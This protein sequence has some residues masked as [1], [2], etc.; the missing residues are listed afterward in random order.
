MVISVIIPV[1]NGELAI[2]R[3][4]GSVINQTYKEIEIICVDDASTDDTPD[5]LKEYADKD[6][7]IHILTES[8]NVGTSKA[9]K[10]GV[11]M[12]KGEHILFLD[13]D[14]ELEQCACER[15]LQ[16]YR[17]HKWDILQFGVEVIGARTVNKE[18]IQSVTNYVEPIL[19]ELNISRERELCFDK[20][21]NAHNLCGKFMGGSVVRKAFSLLSDDRLLMGEDLYAFY[22][23]SLLADGYFGIDDKLYK[24]YYGNGITGNRRSFVELLEIYSSSVQVYQQCVKI[25]KKLHMEEECQLLL[26]GI[27]RNVRESCISFLCASDETTKREYVSASEKILK[28]YWSAEDIQYMCARLLQER[29]R[30]RNRMAEIIY[31]KH[32]LFPYDR[33]EKNTEIILYGAGDVG[34]DYYRQMKYT[35]YCKV[36]L[37]VDQ[38]KCGSTIEGCVISPIDDMTLGSKTAILLAVEDKNIQNK[39]K[40]NLVK[41]GIEE[42]RLINL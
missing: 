34:V 21:Q 28:Q 33:I 29:I 42:K 38:I 30:M 32:W 5:I 41:Y 23:I 18:K 2:R 15:L 10:D 8:S 27:G 31:K 36:I 16:V 3:S 20:Q 13:A 1:Y 25:T 19:G 40:E 17:K 14:D 22:V 6:C 12:S 9:R 24:Y 26:E 37:W 35:G 11:K 4:V 39:I 7:R